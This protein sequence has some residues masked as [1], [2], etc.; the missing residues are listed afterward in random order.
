[1]TEDEMVGWHHRL[2]G[3]EFEQAPTV[4]DG[5]GGV[6]CCSPRGRK[7]P[8]TTKGRKNDEQ[9][10]VYIHSGSASG[11]PLGR[12]LLRPSSGVICI[13]SLIPTTD[14]PYNW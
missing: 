7:E 6:A 13:R 5:Q 14:L 4:D 3:Q 10:H 1:M 12:Q 2:N 8:D 11:T 9:Q